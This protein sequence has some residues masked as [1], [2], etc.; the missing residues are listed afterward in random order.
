MTRVVIVGGGFAGVKAARVL[1]A[2]N[3][4][5]VTLISSRPDFEYHAALY[6][7]ATGHSPLEVAIPLAEI[8]QRTKVKICHDSLTKID[9]KAKTVTGQNG[10]VYP[11]DKLILALGT[12]TAY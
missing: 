3:R 2:D 12:V 6:R 5:A 9:A 1:A 7:S 10:T 8:L 11:Y 4:F